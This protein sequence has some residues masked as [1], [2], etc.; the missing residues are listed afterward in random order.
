MGLTLSSW[1]DEFVSQ[2][3]KPTNILILGL[4]NAGKTQILYCMKMGHAITNTVPTLGFNL[5]EISYKHLTFK[6]WDLGGQTKFRQMWHHYYDD[7]DAVI[8]VLDSQD[9]DRFK[10]AKH[11]LEAL[12]NQEKLRNAPFLIFANKQ[13][14]PQA[15]EVTEIKKVLEWH[16]WKWKENFHLVACTALENHRI[17]N[18]MDWLASVI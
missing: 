15:A 6:A 9:R 16:R 4:D 2:F 18:G 5:E 7:T 13:D 12:L 17:K 3:Y 11:E 8:F 1:I 10:E 14:L